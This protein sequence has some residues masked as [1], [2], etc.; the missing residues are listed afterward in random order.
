MNYFVD[1]DN[2]QLNLVMPRILNIFAL[3]SGSFSFDTGWLYL[4]PLFI[5]IKVQTKDEILYKIGLG[6]FLAP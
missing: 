2:T 5:A 1:I 3:S 4:S 6:L